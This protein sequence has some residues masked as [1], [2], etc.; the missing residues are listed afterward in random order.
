R[1]SAVEVVQEPSPGRVA[2]LRDADQDLPGGARCRLHRDDEAVVERIVGD[3]RI[4]QAGALAGGHD[5]RPEGRGADRADGRTG[6]FVLAT[7]VVV[8]AL[9]LPRRTAT[10][11]DTRR[12]GEV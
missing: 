4:G 6:D 9:D 12:D 11:V 2:R 10:A 7:V 5:G 3:A 1:M 8:V